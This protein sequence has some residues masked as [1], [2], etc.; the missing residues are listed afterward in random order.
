MQVH[1]HNGQVCTLI[2][3]LSCWSISLF[4][5]IIGIPYNCVNIYNF[6]ILTW[7]S[8]D[9]CSDILA[10]A[11]M[12]FI[13]VLAAITN[14]MNIIIGIKLLFAQEILGIAST[15]SKR[16]K[17]KTREMFIQNCFQDCVY[18]IDT[19]NSMF[20]YTW[21]GNILYQFMFTIFSNLFVHVA[22]GCIMLYFNHDK[23]QK[24]QTIKITSHLTQVVKVSSVY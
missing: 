14:T 11:V 17:R 19:L 13:M 18:L 5:S 7:D 10:D 3:L 22:D 15:E 2:A 1:I 16:R 23:V 9:P 4:V 20:V 8:L 6:D 21:S 12:Y 24:P